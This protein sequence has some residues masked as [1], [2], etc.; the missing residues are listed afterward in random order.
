MGFF[1][2]VCAMCFSARFFVLMLCW[3]GLSACQTGQGP[4]GLL[5]DPG[6]R[7]FNFD[8]RL[9][10][11]PQVGPLQIFDNGVRTWLHFAP[12]QILPAV[13]G[14]RNGQEILL[15]LK[16]SGQFQLVDG[17]WPDLVFRAGRAEAKA[18]PVIEAVKGGGSGAGTAQQDSA[19]P[20]LPLEESLEQASLSLSP[21]QQL[22]P[23][24][25]R[26][27]QGG[28]SAL[29]QEGAV[30]T[31]ELVAAQSFKPNSTLLQVRAQATDEKPPVLPVFE[32]RLKDRTLRQ[33]LMRWAK[34]AK[35]VFGAEHWN[36]EVDFPIKAAAH[37]EGGFESAVA[38]LLAAAQLN[39]H[40]LQ[41]CFY[42]NQVLRVLDGSQDCDPGASP[43]GRP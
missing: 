26:G 29:A 28:G 38:R 40:P 13:F 6:T 43:E 10:G 22:V 20:K 39:G 2:W 4:D 8:W 24:S 18:S 21:I 9:S 34:Q 3:L 12:E 19:S 16:P 27:G 36:L 37:F 14:R 31:A 1:L 15:S 11:D 7:V 23:A 32:L 42:S 17:V 5:A 41:A 33:A 25:N 35:W 30:V